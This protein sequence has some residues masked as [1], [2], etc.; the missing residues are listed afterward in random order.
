MRYCG[1]YMWD[2]SSAGLSSRGRTV[3]AE[4]AARD[5][6]TPPGG[7]SKGTRPAVVGTAATGDG[8]R[9]ARAREERSWGRPPGIKAVERAEVRA[10]P[11]RRAEPD[12]TLW[13]EGGRGR[14]SG[15]TSEKNKGDRR[16]EPYYGGGERGARRQCCPAAGR[17]ILERRSPTGQALQLGAYE[18]LDD[19]GEK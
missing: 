18:M 7:G 5:V 8:G 16:R 10:A 3:R 6:K 17:F 12:A 4:I 15:R 14:K 11:A 1:L 19:P 9:A 13:M 2:A